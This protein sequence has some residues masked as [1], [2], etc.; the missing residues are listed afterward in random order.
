M[1]TKE[2]YLRMI[3]E[4]YASSNEDDLDDY[5]DCDAWVPAEPIVKKKVGP[6]SNLLSSVDATNLKKDAI[7][8]IIRRTKQIN[9]GK[10]LVLIKDHFE[11]KDESFNVIIYET[12]NKTPTG[13]SCNIQ[14]KVNMSKD[15][16]FS[17]RKWKNNFKNGIFGQKLSPEALVDVL[18]WLQAVTKLT[19]FL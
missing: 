7:E 4:A 19:C 9:V 18:K 10:F 11:G 17:D 8:R 13:L 1:I 3:R 14:V 2:D 15:S 6:V 12:K 5:I 16:R